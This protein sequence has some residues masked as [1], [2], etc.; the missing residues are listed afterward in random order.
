MN[1][2]IFQQLVQSTL[3]HFRC[4]G[5]CGTIQPTNIAIET[6]QADQAVLEIICPH[7]GVS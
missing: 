2:V 6:I 1:F 4:Q 7:C 5:C 3:E